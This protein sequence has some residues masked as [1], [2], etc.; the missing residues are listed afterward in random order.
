MATSNSSMKNDINILLLG[1]TGV[2][3]STF[4]NAFANY[5]Y[6]EKM[7]DAL[8]GNLLSVIPASF[9]I[10]D[11]ESY[12]Q[13]KIV[14]GEDKNE[15]WQTGQSS[16]Q[17]C[18][19]YVF[20]IDNA[21]NLRIIDTPG[22]GDTRGVNEDKKN[23]Q[24]ILAYISN[25]DHI[26][27]ICLLLKPNEARLT[28]FFRF[29]VKELLTHLHRNATRNMI[30]CFTNARSTFYS[31][32]ETA[33]LL[34]QLLDEIR[35]QSGVDVPFCKNNT[36]CFDNESFR[37]VAAYK[38]GVHFDARAKSDYKQSWEK[39]VDQSQQ[40]ILMIKQ[41]E[42]HVVTDTISL[43]QARRLINELTRP[44]AEIAR[45]IQ[46]NIDVAQSKMDELNNTR[47]AMTDLNNKLRVPAVDL[48][49]TAL[50]YPRTVC[51]AT[52]CT[53]RVQLH[54]TVKIDYRT[55]CHPRCYL[56]GVAQ[57]VVNNA[58]LKQCSAM[59]SNGKCNGCGCSWESHMHITYETKQVAV[60]IVDESIASQIR[61][62]EEAAAAIRKVKDNI[63]QRI[64]QLK[65]EREI[66][67]STCAKLSKFLHKNAITP[68]NDDLIKYVE[69]VI[70]NEEEKRGAGAYNQKVITGLKEMIAA[71]Q[72][73]MNVYKKMLQSAQNDPR[74]DAPQIEEIYQL[75]NALYR[76]P[77][78]G[79]KLKGQIDII[80]RGSNVVASQYDT[81]CKP[82]HS[83]S[84]LTSLWNT[85]K[86]N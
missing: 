76:L 21:T 86:G 84:K 58:A 7:E 60:E 9:V 26:N 75:I 77:I 3:K 64:N 31:P 33:P 39:S 57:N 15:T 52:K 59:D 65:Q 72:Q 14:I 82:P 28:I 37:F 30:F 78:S 69:H 81:V 8:K 10:T 36:F 62:K 18:R 56:N 41:F 19:S 83:K 63:L 22:V 25:F 55:H 80:R 54:D 61:T 71:Y 12:E 51:T 5:V 66:L 29:C 85:I 2:G 38:Q 68:Y 32:G 47:L 44:I 17:S 45:N 6:Y 35:Q 42:P 50:D 48:E 79:S 43:N 23:F 4:I 16:T 70:G 40:L 11:P 74:A 1:E 34:K 13:K 53:A 73:E 20:P 67:M 49:S 27:G 46:V 24:N